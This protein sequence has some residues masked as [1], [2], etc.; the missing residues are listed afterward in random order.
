M[1]SS[2]AG[3]RSVAV[4]GQ[5]GHHYCESFCEAGGD[6][7]PRKVVLRV[8]MQQQQRWPVAADPQV[9]L[10]TADVDSPALEPRKDR[11]RLGSVGSRTQAV[12]LV[13]HI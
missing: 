4:A 9:D 1:V 10:N 7:V 5:I 6:T 2:D 3:L 13:S 12:L 11:A 8:T